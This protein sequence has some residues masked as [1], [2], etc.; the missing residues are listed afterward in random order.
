MGLINRRHNGLRG[1]QTGRF[2]FF[3]CVDEPEVARRLLRAV[4]RWGRSRGMQRLVGPMGFSDQDPEGLLVEGFEFE[5][6]LATYSNPQYV[7]DLLE[8][9]GYAKEVDYVTYMV[10]VRIP[11]AYERILNRVSRGR[12]RLIEFR[13]RREIRPYVLPILR[14]MNESFEGL[15]GYVPMDDEEMAALAGRY[16]P[17]LD[18][19]F[20][21]VVI[22]GDDVIGFIVAVPNLARGLRRCR[23][24]LFPIGILQL[25]HAARTTK[26]LDLLL[27]GIRKDCRGRG[28][29]V[30][31]GAAMFRSGQ[32]A[33]LRLLDSHHVL[34]TNWKM[35]AELERAGGRVCKRHRIYHKPLPSAE[36]AP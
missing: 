31:L 6:S 21:K 3:D 7:G 35:R 9:N 10:P 5:P 32:Q 27:G 2:G 28:V 25:W 34:E 16:L 29:D 24:R 8:T 15:Y 19:R 12:F 13:R 14:V 22:R 36:G 30:L 4:E 26:Q 33:G 18:P 1:E 17:L 11:Q 23:G 20:I